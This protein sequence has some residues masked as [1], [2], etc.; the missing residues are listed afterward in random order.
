MAEEKR[1]YY[2]VL[3]VQKGCSDDELKKA[4]RKLAKQYHP[5][6]NP[7]DKDAEAKFKEVNEAYAVLSD[8]EKRARYDQF[9]H[10]GVDPSYGGGAGG[11]GGFGFDFGDIGDIFAGNPVAGVFVVAMVLSLAMP[12]H[13][14]AESIDALTPESIETPNPSTPEQRLH[15]EK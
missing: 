7:G 11:A 8:S 4:Y 9:G 2:E 3:G 10:A 5:D 12:K 6:L 13:V 15:K 1:D 14:K